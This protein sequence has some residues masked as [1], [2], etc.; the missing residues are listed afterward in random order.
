MSKILIVDDDPRIVRMLERY[1]VGEGF[2]V[3][4]AS[5]G[6]SAR[7]AFAEGGFAVILLDLQLPDADGLDLA[8]EFRAQSDVGIIILTGKGDPIDRVVGLE[9]GADDYVAKPFH[10]RE[11][12]ARIK[13]LLRRVRSEAE[14]TAPGPGTAEQAGEEDASGAFIDFGGFR[15]DRFRQELSRPDGTAVELTTGEFKLL[16]A[17]V[18]HP[19]R[20][21]SRDQLLDITAGREWSPFDRSVDTQ[22]RRLRKKLGD[23]AGAKDLIKTV[24]GSGY[25]FTAQVNRCG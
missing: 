1:L 11:V 16:E 8:R 6:A 24:R 13:S 18:S 25:L 3:A 17:F 21:L 4:A 9:V 5:D 12:L 2:D 10:M 7:T 19:R 23:D 14:K 22:V 20:V 15:L